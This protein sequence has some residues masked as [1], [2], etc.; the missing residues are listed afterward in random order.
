MLVRKARNVH[1]V[2]LVTQMKREQNAE[3]QTALDE[4]K[5]SLKRK[6]VDLLIKYQEFHDRYVRLVLKDVAP[7]MWYDS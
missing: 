4:L 6:N 1:T 5:D 3:Q 2:T 7:N